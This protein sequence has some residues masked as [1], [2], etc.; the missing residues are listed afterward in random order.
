MFFGLFIRLHGW[1]ASRT[2]SVLD[3]CAEGPGF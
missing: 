3:S 1:L 2:V